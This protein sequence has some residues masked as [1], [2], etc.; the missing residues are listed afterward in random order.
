MGYKRY[1]LAFWIRLI[2][3]QLTMLAFAY[4]LMVKYWY[5]SSGLLL[6][7]ILVQGWSFLKQIGTT[8][9]K[10]SLFL[11]QASAKDYTLSFTSKNEGSGFDELHKSMNQLISQLKESRIDKEAQFMLFSNMIQNLN[12]G[13][14]VVNNREEILLSNPALHKMLETPQEKNWGRFQKRNPEIGALLLELKSDE[15]RITNISSKDAKTQQILITKRKFYI[16]TVDFSFYSFQNI[17]K[18]LEKKEIESWHKLIR[19]LTHEIMNSVSPVVSLS[20]TLK[21]LLQNSKESKEGKLLEQKIFEDIQLSADTIQNRSKGLLE[22][23][24]EYSK[25]TRI[26]K[27]KIEQLKLGKILKELEL[28]LNEKLK[29]SNVDF[30]IKLDREDMEIHADGALLEQVLLN[31]INNA[32]EAIEKEAEPK[33]TITGNFLNGHTR[34]SIIDNGSGIEKEIQKDIFLPF[35]TTKEKGSGIGLSLSKN[36]IIAHGGELNYVPKEKGSCFVIELP[37]V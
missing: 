3:L 6:I 2:V 32:I 27:P 9:K 36:I 37:L 4:C 34:I 7:L 29:K 18:E 31:L 15:R 5:L 24:E 12:T 23:I 13:I 8:N 26:P 14:I 33:I 35:F 17:H 21:L 22:F 30:N 28:L 11:S 20:S 19:I 16:N 10:V 1:N 25:L